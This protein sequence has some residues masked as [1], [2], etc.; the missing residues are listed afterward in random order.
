L[1]LGTS[2]AGSFYDLLST[3]INR[4]DAFVRRA[5]TQRLLLLKD[6]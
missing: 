1:P 2:S 6:A 4:L 5:D 3:K